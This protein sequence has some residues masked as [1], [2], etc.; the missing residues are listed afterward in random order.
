MCAVQGRGREAL[1]AGARRTHSREHAQRRV[2]MG[3]RGTGATALRGIGDAGGRTREGENG[4]PEAARRDRQCV[5]GGEGQGGMALL[6]L[7]RRHDSVSESPT[8]L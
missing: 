6:R 8:G 5:C 4:G 2:A 7:R 3:V 1:S